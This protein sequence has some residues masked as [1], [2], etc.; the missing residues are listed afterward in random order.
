[1]SNSITVIITTY[2]SAFFITN[3][4]TSIIN[5]SLKP[6][7]IIVIDDNSDDLK[8]LKKIIKKIKNKN[9]NNIELI[10]NSKNM[11]PGFNRNLAWSFCKT[12]FIAFCDDDDYW[13]KDK[14]KYQIQIFE[15][16]RNTKL[17]ASKKKYL[18]EFSKII[19]KN[20]NLNLSKISFFKLLFK[21]YIPTSSV[22]IK[23]DLKDRFSNEYY[24]EDYFLWLS[25]LKKNYE[26]YLIKDYLCEEINIKNR[27]KLSSNKNKIYKGALNVLN[28]FYNDNIFNN[29]LISLA[30]LYYYFKMII[31]TLK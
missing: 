9:F 18:K 20:I 16:K 25:I 22:V 29:L 10:S 26:C 19:N 8:I 14:L 11:G 13:H 2:N 23:S 17:V 21:N 31:K 7:K 24:A 27:I 30:K 1:M 4:I 3:T 6:N 28:Q 5:Q 12:T 15:K